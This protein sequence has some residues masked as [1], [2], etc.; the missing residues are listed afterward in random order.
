MFDV[1]DRTT[2]FFLVFI[3]LFVAMDPLGSLPFLVPFLGRIQPSKR[4]RVIRIALATGLL[5]GLAFLGLGK[6]LFDVLGISVAD[7]LVAGGLILLVV[8]LRDMIGSA[9][10]EPPEPDELLAVVPIGTPLLIGPAAISMLILQ[11]SLRGVGITLVAFAA[12]LLLAWLVFTFSARIGTF[13][14]RGGM[15]ALSRVADLLLAAIAIQLIRRGIIDIW[16]SLR[17]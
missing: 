13:L 15:L 10:A 5:L 2:D 16:V 8:S 1:W 6:A 11:S 4:P 17:A 12:N 14:G 3:P 7:F 9:P